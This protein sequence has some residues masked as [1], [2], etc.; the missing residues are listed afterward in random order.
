[1][2]IVKNQA[3]IDCLQ[4][5]DSKARDGEKNHVISEKLVHCIFVFWV[6]TQNLTG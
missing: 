2:L 3:V 6:N 5:V 4:L 1:M